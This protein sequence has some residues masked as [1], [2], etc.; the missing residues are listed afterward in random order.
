MT[1]TAKDT[2]KE[3]ALNAIYRKYLTTIEGMGRDEAVQ[4]T[5]DNP[6]PFTAD[7]LNQAIAKKRNLNART[8]R[9]AQPKKEK[10]LE[11]YLNPEQIIEARRLVE[12]GIRGN[13]LKMYLRDLY[14][15]SDK[16]ILQAIV[17][18]LDVKVTRSGGTRESFDAKFNSFCA[19][20]LRTQDEVRA[21]IQEFGGTEYNKKA[22]LPRMLS[23][24]EFFASVHKKYM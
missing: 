11:D 7:E 4:F 18:L 14:R 13:T 21:F 12:Q 1:T 6:C 5:R 10:T 16:A 20:K 24:A 19:E 17:T 8:Y 15:I 2:T 9:H 23:R 22:T 3:Q